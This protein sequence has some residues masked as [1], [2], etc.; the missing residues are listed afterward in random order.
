MLTGKI[1]APAPLVASYPRLQEIT[2][3]AELTV[4]SFVPTTKPYRV[5]PSIDGCCQPQF[6][7]ALVTL[8]NQWSHSV[9]LVDSSCRKT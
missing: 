4:P 5:S 9:Q 8:G 6:Y 2:E 3:L 1:G 7:V